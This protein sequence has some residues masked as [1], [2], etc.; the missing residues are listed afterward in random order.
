ML[1]HDTASDC[2]AEIEMAFYKTIG[3][4]NQNSPL[5]HRKPPFTGMVRFRGVRH[6]RSGDTKG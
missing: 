2:S 1:D 5:E 4:L 6:K 3:V